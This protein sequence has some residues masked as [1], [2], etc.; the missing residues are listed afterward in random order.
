MEKNALNYS[1]NFIRE[2]VYDKIKVIIKDN[3]N[4]EFM[5]N[6]EQFIKKENETIN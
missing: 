3:M 2:K 5:K 1:T 4:N 6:K